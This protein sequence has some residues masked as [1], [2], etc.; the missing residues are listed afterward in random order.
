M[1]RYTGFCKVAIFSFAACCFCTA[2]VCADDNT[3]DAQLITRSGERRAGGVGPGHEGA[4]HN[5]EGREPQRRTNQ[6]QLPNEGHGAAYEKGFNQGENQG[7]NQGGGY[8]VPVDPYYYNG[9]QPPSG[10]PAPKT[11]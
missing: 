10:Y 7:G 11:P 1:S 9:N 2:L 8:A 6:E 5:Y 4:H 3:S